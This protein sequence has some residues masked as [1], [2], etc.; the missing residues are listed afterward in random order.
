[1]SYSLY[2]PFMPTRH[3]NPRASGLIVFGGG[4]GDGGTVYTDAAGGTHAT[5]AD[6]IA[7]NTAAETAAVAAVEAKKVADAKAAAEAKVISDAK[8]AD[9]AAISAYISGLSTAISAAPKAGDALGLLQNQLNAVLTFAKPAATYTATPAEIAAEGYETFE[10]KIQ[11]AYDSKIT[12]LQAKIQKNQSQ[13]SAGLA[14]GQR[15]LVSAAITDPTSLTTTADVAKIND[16]PIDPATGLPKVE[17]PAERTARLSQLEV[18]TGTGDLAT[19][20]GATAVTGTA[21]GADPVEDIEVAKVTANTS[22]AAVDDAL[23]NTEAAQGT[24]S[25]DSLVVAATSDGTTGVS[26]LKAA[27]GK[28]LVMENPTTRDLQAGEIISGVADAEKAAVFTEQIQAA[29]ATPSDKATVQ[30]QMAGL[31]EGFDGSSAPAWASAALRNATAQMAARGMGASSMAGQA[32]LQ[33]TMEAAL[34]IAAQDA[35]T[36]AGFEMANLSNRQQRAMLAA[37]QRAAFLGQEFDQ[38]FQA[39]VQNASRIADIA[40]MNFTAEQ[41]IALENSRNANSMNMANLSNRQA[42]IMGEAAAISNLEMASLSNQ[43]QAAVQN[44]QSFLQMD[45]ANLANRQ[46]TELFKSQTLIQSIFTDQAAVN[47]AAQFN[48][49]SENQTNQFLANMRTQVSQFNASQTNSMTQFNTNEL[50]GMAKFNAD[51]TNQRDQFNA[52]NQLVVAQA[53]ALWRQS[54]TTMDTAAQNVANAEAAKTSNAFTASTLDQIWQR[55]RD[56]MSMA[57]KSSESSAERANAIIMAQ[58]GIEAQTAALATQRAAEESSAV[59]SFFS[60]LIFGF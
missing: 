25:D 1:M 24:V 19:M 16:A 50:N 35:Q 39:K 17:T 2:N 40:N 57:W 11:A 54:V 7:A 13:S 20:T 38:A 45:M 42:L 51:M 32:I 41:Q 4:G 43:Q 46:Q 31:M 36:V 44:A 21:I 28:S 5:E 47:A 18:A 6:A 55:E 12:D 29:Q 26:D 22:K 34:P 9:T 23:N 33:A 10:A 58:M 14:A 37:E 30:G 56:M 60:K 3:L 15:A 27:Q 52:T 49:S 8:A 48:A 53:N 59:G